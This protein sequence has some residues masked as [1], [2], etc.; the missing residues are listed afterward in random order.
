MARLAAT[1]PMKAT[2]ARQMRRTAQLLDGDHPEMITGDHLRDAAKVLEHGQL[3]GAKRHLDAAMELLTPRNLYRHG[4]TDDDGH[5][6]A[7][8]HMHQVHRHRLAVQ[9]I[10]DTAGRNDRLRDAARAVRENGSAAGVA[11]PR[12]APAAAQLATGPACR[13]VDMAGWEQEARGPGGKW[14]KGAYD[15]LLSHPELDT[16]D[17]QDR[18][19]ITHHLQRARSAA[20][21]GDHTMAE[22]HLKDARRRAVSRGKPGLAAGAGRLANYH[23]RQ[24]AAQLGTKPLLSQRAAAR[25]VARQPKSADVP[26][27]VIPSPKRVPF[28]LATELSARTAMLER[29]PAPR[30]RPGGPGL[31]HVA[32]MGHTPYLQQIV[33]ALIEKRGMPPD[34]AYKIA[35]GAIRRWMHG[36]GHVHPEV[37][38]AA[39]KA[40]AGEDARQARAHVHT[41]DPWELVDTLIELA[42]G[43]PQW[44]NESRVAQGQA[45][46][47]QFGAGQQQG[48]RAAK[49]R[50]LVKQI[51]TLRARLHTLESQYKA[52]TGHS[53]HRSASAT[54]RKTGAGATSAAAAKAAASKTAAGSTA[55]AAKTASPATLHARIVALRAQLAA[56]LAQLRRL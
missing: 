37:R 53:S 16:M 10:E 11:V 27:R 28:V 13:V 51:A 43:G 45:G 8:H 41:A 52:A 17:S 23:L 46:G 36:G 9:D 22:L 5:A 26:A 48:G 33:K 32:G 20:L 30:G 40:E 47:G 14:V 7:K 2:V 49:R 55:T 35:R 3:D 12:F 34:K 4:I 31:Y 50:A 15:R 24:S 29:T 39:G 6:L 44:K 21:S 18:A 19:V 56:D 54:P 38:A 25:F 42:A 1:G